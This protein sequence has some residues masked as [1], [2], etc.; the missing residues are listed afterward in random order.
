[1]R[2]I[3]QLT[4]DELTDQLLT[5]PDDDR[6]MLVHRLWASLKSE[7][8]KPEDLNE[9]DNSPLSPAWSTEVKRRMAAFENG[10]S[11]A[12]PGDD[13]LAQARL[14]LERFKQ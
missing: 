9:D 11:Q 1:M 6:A 14:V 13:A 5:L 4:I 8:L 10:T 7:D 2:S 3:T 12:I